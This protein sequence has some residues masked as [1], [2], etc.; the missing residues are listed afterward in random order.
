MG[1]TAVNRNDI[2]ALFTAAVAS[3]FFLKKSLKEEQR[4]C[5]RRMVC[6]KEDIIVVLTTGFGNSVIY[7]LEHSRKKLSFHLHRLENACSCGESF[8]ICSEATSCESKTT[9]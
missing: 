2:W 4:E 1:E 8:G 9:E 6:L 3:T 7:S 5:I